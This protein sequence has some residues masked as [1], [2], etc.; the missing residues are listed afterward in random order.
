MKK[1]WFMTILCLQVEQIFQRLTH[2]RQVGC[3]KGR[4]MQQHIWSVVSSFQTHSQG[5]LVSFDF[6]NAFPILAHNFIKAVLT[7][8]QL[9]A[10]LIEFIMSTLTAPYMFCVGQGVVPEVLFFPRAGIGQGDPF[11]P[12][13]FS[14]YVS[15]LLHRL[16][17]LSGTD[18]YLYVDDLYVMLTGRKFRKRLQG[19]IF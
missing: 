12:L 7:Q 5:A 14:F 1:K 13:L 9:P 19:M 15:F 10:M 4:S 18:P 16:S 2:K 11:S 6:S 3:V 8:I 17:G